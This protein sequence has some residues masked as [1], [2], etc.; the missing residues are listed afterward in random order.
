MK[1]LIIGQHGT[2]CPRNSTTIDLIDNSCLQ[3]LKKY[4]KRKEPDEK[5]EEEEEGF[6]E[7]KRK[8]ER[9]TDRQ[10][11][12]HFFYLLAKEK[13]RKLA[14][15]SGQRQAWLQTGSKNEVY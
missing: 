6:N 13:L 5:K 10:M 9:Q 8:R 15:E 2:D 7:G 4:S 3:V 11:K 14:S 1:Q 12:W